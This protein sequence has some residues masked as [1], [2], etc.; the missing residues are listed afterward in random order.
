[1]TI[2]KPA[3]CWNTRIVIAAVAHICSLATAIPAQAQNAEPSAWAAFNDI[4]KS[5]TSYTA[6]V[7]VFEREG[8]EVQSSV[9]DYTFRKPSSATVHFTAGPNAG[10]TVVW[11]GADTVVAHRGSGFAALFKKTFSLH[12]PHVTTIRR[13]SIDQL[14]FAG[15]LAHSQGTPGIVSQDVGPAILDIPTVAVTLVP[16]SSVADTGLTREVVDISVPTGLPLRILGYEGNTLV[17]QIDFSN[18]I[19]RP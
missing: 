11:N 1:M 5:V 3:A 4:W 17:R 15:I 12:D 10:V 7:I 2:R 13:S 18:I 9:L 19:L 16:T 14:S 6:T 8:T